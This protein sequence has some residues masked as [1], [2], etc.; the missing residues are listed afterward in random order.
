MKSILSFIGILF[1][2]SIASAQII[3][4]PTYS[5]GWDI[6]GGLTTANNQTFTL[7][8]DKLLRAGP[9]PVICTATSNPQTATCTTPIPALT[10]GIHTMRV[11]A[12]ELVNGV[13]VDSVFSEE[14]TF[15]MRVIQAPLN[16]RI[17]IRTA[18]TN[19]AVPNGTLIK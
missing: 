3:A 1:F 14:L 16:P 2:S 7:E 18:T 9:V 19:P 8:L 11:K 5:F 4:L 13:P 17:I 12:T 6:E 15:E 10:P